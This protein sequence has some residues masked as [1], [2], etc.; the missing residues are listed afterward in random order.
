MTSA[1]W[2]AWAALGADASGSGMILHTRNGGANWEEQTLPEDVDGIKGIKGLT[3]FEAWAVSLSGI[4]LHTTNKGRTWSIVDHP[5]VPILQVNRMDAIGCGDLRNPVGSFWG[6][7]AINANIW[8]VDEQ[9]GNHGLI[10]S[11]YN[12]E[13]WRQEYVPYTSISDG[14]HMV[15]AYSPRVV[16]SAAWGNGT[17]FRT[18]DGGENWTDVAVVGGLNDIDDMCALRADSLW[19]VLN[20][21]GASGGNIFHA[22]LKDGESP[23]IQYFDPATGYLYEG[24]TC[25]GD[26]TALTVG[27]RGVTLDPSLPAGVILST[28]DGGQSWTNHSLPVDDVYLW[29]TSF[30][31]ARR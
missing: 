23:A 15:S 16:W 21:S 27:L 25:V 22:Q 20:L 8:I 5:S 4:V 2:T 11:P 31:G 17:L 19:G 14:M 29:K 3:R 10:H 13:S 12:G 7:A 18:V 26:R 30:V 24:L 28:T 1:Q 9:G 6:Q